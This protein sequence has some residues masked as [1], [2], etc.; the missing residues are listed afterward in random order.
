MARV[1]LPPHKKKQTEGIQLSPDV[2]DTLAQL[3][4]RW[5]IKRSAAGRRVLLLGLSVYEFLEQHEATLLEMLTCKLTDADAK[6]SPTLGFAAKFNNLPESE[7]AVVLAVIES[8]Y[9]K[10]QP[11]RTAPEAVA[12]DSRERVLDVVQFL[13]PERKKAE[14]AKT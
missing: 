4:R 7:Q 14:A 12:T 3:G 5:G 8:I 9:N 10:T 6:P 13:P 1:K 11:A 2:L